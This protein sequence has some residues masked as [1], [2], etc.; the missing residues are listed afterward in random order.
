MA[1]IGISYWGFCEK[2]G[3]CNTANTPDGHRYGRPIL[4][5]DLSQRGH[6]VYALQEKREIFAYPN[7]LYAYDR[8]PDLDVLFVEWR[9]ST[10]KNS[11]SNKFEPDLDRQIEL[12]DYYHDKIPIVA[13]DTDLKMTREDEARWPN[14][15]VADPTLNPK[16]F[17]IPRIRLTFW[18]DF[19]VLF[20]P[21]GDAVEFGYIGNNYE[22]DEMFKKYYSN[23]ACDLRSGGIQTKVWGNWLQRSPERPSPEQ[24]IQ[25]H[26]Y[27]A[28]ADRVSF[29]E[30]MV[31]L[32]KFICTIHITKPRYAKQG[33]C[34]PRYLENIV[35]NT[36]ALVPS[37]FCRNTALGNYWKVES[38]DDVVRKLFKLQRLS[39][40]DRGAIVSEQRENLLKVHDFS[41]GYVSDLLEDIIR[42][43]N[44]AIRNVG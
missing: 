39:P 3:N 29:K 23:P 24:I 21:Y 35:A 25:K 26:P 9:W 10:Y 15:I 11:G 30:S 31:I 38:A 22:R 20:E 42:D 27:V 14:M 32:N 12:L 7:L 37:E 41:V 43:P 28:F 2:L 17:L 16:S 1:K 13:W 5:D 40:E 44:S 36:P 34:S 6:I 4:V 19:K 33:F 8:F 18:S